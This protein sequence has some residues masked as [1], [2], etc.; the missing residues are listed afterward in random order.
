MSKIINLTD[1]FSKDEQSSIQIGNKK[2]PINNS[3]EA[4][5]GFEELADGATVKGLLNAIEGALGKKAVDEIG[6]TKMT[7]ENLKVLMSGLVAAMQGL[8]YEEAA[9]RFQQ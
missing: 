8:T 9:A 5:L 1:K 4:V 3:V 7:V 6:V 2:Y